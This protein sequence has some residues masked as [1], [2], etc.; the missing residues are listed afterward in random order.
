[1]RRRI[2]C[3]LVSLTL[4]SLCDSPLIAQE[5]GT[6]KGQFVLNGPAPKMETITVTA[7]KEICSKTPPSDETWVVDATGGLANVIVYCRS[8]V[9][10]KPELAATIANTPVRL[11]NKNC[12]FEPRVVA[13]AMGQKLEIHNSD[14]VG[15][16]AKISPFVATGSS[17]MIPPGAVI[18]KKYDDRENNAV[19]VAC[20]IHPWMK[21]WLFI[22]PNPYFAVSAKDGTFEIKGLPAGNELEFVAWH[23]GNGNVTKPTVAGKAETWKKGRFKFTIKP[24]VNDLGLIRI[25]P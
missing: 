10:V 7:D 19:S 24:G 16:N 9:N 20:S 5:W 25:T 3:A 13:V 8:D 15:H 2:L 21:A 12:R 14:P 17:D 4:V 11:D 22:C 18:T 6:L 1:M 23:E